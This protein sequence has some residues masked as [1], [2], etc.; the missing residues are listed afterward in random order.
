[1]LEARV[2]QKFEM[3]FFVTDQAYRGDLT[4]GGFLSVFRRPLS[5]AFGDEVNFLLKQGLLVAR[6]GRIAKTHRLDFQAVHL[7]AFLLGNG[8]DPGRQMGTPAGFAGTSSLS[9][10][11]N[12]IVSPSAA[13]LG[14]KM[15]RGDAAAEDEWAIREYERAGCELPPSMLW[16]RLAIRAAQASRGEQR[17]VGKSGL[18]LDAT[19]DAG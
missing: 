7:L 19:P 8:P 9:S 2:D 6:G 10:Q 14:G 11:P 13:A 12:D 3:A 5:S 18:A 1:M 16:T 15:V 4:T 17:M